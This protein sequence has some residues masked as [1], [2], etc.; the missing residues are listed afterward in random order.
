[1]PESSL[2]GRRVLIVEDDYFLAD[3]LRAEFQQAG[4][5]VVGPVGRVSEALDLV[6][7]D[8]RIH[9]AVLD[10]NLAGE[11]VFGV[12]DALRVKNVPFVFVTGYDAETIPAAYASVRTYEKPI[13]PATIGNALF[14]R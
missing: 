2:K 10:I 12:A 14:R 3:E 1:M 11:M 4:A 9:G 7:R 5:E 6:E 8:G 13:D